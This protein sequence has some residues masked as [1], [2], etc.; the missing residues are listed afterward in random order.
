LARTQKF[1][2]YVWRINA[3]LIFV[4]A[5]AAVVGVLWLVGS[6]IESSTRHRNA[7]A[8]APP[9][10]ANAEKNHLRLGGLAHIDGTSVYRA[11]LSSDTEGVSLG[12]SGYSR[13]T[14][15]ILFINLS[16][17][18]G[19]WLLPSDHEVITFNEDV[20]EPFPTGETHPP[21]A[22]VVLAKPYASHPESVTGRILVM[23]AA[24]EHISEVASGVADVHGV[25]LTPTGEIAVLFERD[26]QYQVALFEKASLR[27]ISER[28]IDAPLLH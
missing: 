9:V 6:E 24:A 14:R 10:V 21:L 7:V 2:R 25:S 5:A 27:K 23:D 22:T 8:A 18:A 1:F 17:G 20:T 4:A 11:K 15:N 13:D 26:R 19:K 3:L 16:T 12:S 28:H